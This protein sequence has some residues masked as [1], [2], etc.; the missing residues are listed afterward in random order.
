[1]ASQE[2]TFRLLELTALL[3]PVVAVVLQ[4]LIGEVGASD[5]TVFGRRFD[6]RTVGLTG[7][8]LVIA[9][10]VGTAILLVTELRVQAGVVLTGSRVGY[11]TFLLT[12]ALVAL[13]LLLLALTWW[14]S[15]AAVD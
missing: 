15:E 10:L 1:M 3:L 13:G 11:A 6:Y 5:V 4:V 14:G 9:L 2:L 12:T 7:G 8:G